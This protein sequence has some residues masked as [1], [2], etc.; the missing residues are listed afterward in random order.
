MHPFHDYLSQHLDDLLRK[1]SVVVFY[2]PRSEFTPFFDRELALLDGGPLPLVTIGTSS[3]FLARYE[4]SFFGL[5]AAV[6]P[7]V[8]ADQP[9]PLILYLPGI[10][11]D[12]Q[13]SVLME[14]ERAGTCYEPQLKRLGLNVLRQ[15]FTD[16]QIDEMLRPSAVTYDDIVAFLGQGGQVASV[17]HT[18]FG[19][20]Q[21]E[22]LLT[23]WLAS[24]AKD[25][26]LLEKDALPELLKLIKVRLGLDLPAD[27]SLPRARE[28]TCRY[29]LVNEFRADLSCAPPKS[30]GMVPDP[31]GKECAERIR[32][33]AEGLRRRF[34]DV[35]IGLA[36]SVEQDLGLAGAG[37]EAANLG[38]IDTFRFEEERLLAHAAALIAGKGYDAALAIIDA[39][40][41]SFWVDRD[42]RRQAQWGACRLMAEL[43]HALEGI[44]SALGRVGNDPAKWLAAYVAED[45]WH[46]ADGL[47][48]RLE[49]WV[50][51]MD[52]EPEAEQA[53]AVVRQEHEHLL[54]TMADGFTK[55]FR[56]SA[57]TVAG[58]LHQTRIY[59]EVVQTMGGRVAYFLV[60]A[61]RYEMGV[62]LA[63]QMEGARD[64]T[65]RAAIAALPSITPVGMAALL[66]G[67]AAS[68]DVVDAKGKLAARIE[69]TELKESPDRMR[70]L[71]TKVPDAV[72]MTLGKLLGSSQAKVAKDIGTAPLVVIRSQ[73]I[74][75]VGEMDV[76]LIARQIMD[77]LIGNLARAVKKLAAAGIE[78][79]VITADH[80]HQFSIRKDD[81]MKTDSPGGVTLD[82][83]RRCW[84]GHGGSTPSGAVR[85]P[86]AEL[87]YR[88]DLD[89]VFPTGLGV[90][91]AGGSLSFHHGGFSL[92]E[93]LIP[94]IS[95]RLAAGKPAA[96][97]G[98]QVRIE[99]YPTAVTNRTFGLKLAAAGDLLATEPLMLRVLLMA[100]AEEVGR[101]G[102]AVGADLDRVTGTLTL[103][104]GS[105]AS[106][107]MMLTNDTCQSLRVVVL[108]ARTDGVLAESDELPVKLGI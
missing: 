28:R 3:P 51:G 61:M 63:R 8:A 82:L 23:E 47:Q 95:L 102:M 87:G 19:G 76:D 108:D 81:D 5:R 97:P 6:E 40:V 104:L 80:G 27:T 56:A 45:G 49:T 71:K 7:V 33:V 38:S 11:K 79:F 65:V 29:V 24:D 31:P 1:R 50:A 90:F 84:I 86:C 99:G 54:R 52:D 26:A 88:T 96:V 42:V 92:Q 44:R 35:Y 18:L 39:R 98:I 12:R 89:A 106:V 59:P 15:R 78:R 41:R 43:G 73:E 68:F 2:D 60:D 101:A 74:D 4:G 77:S 103:G 30:V 36:D 32:D 107:G 9:D 14:L 75:L 25:G 66:P 16:G 55:A 53:L 91:K 20:A 46:R 62:E 58:A 93:L 67:A 105:E 94:V 22:V 48:R 70:F 21:G 37:V 13:G 100:G 64:L 85:V 10:A 72:E 69:G 83:H 57:W 34:P 17:L